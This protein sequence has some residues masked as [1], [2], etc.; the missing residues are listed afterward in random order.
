MPDAPRWRA[1]QRHTFVYVARDAHAQV[2]DTVGDPAFRKL[3]AAWLADERPLIVR[4]QTRAFVPDTTPLAVGLALPPAEGKLRLALHV[5]PAAIDRLAPPPALSEVCAKLSLRWQRALVELSRRA[6]DQGIAFRVFGSA[7]WQT[8]TGLQYLTDHS[9]IDLLW[10]PARRESLEA[11]IAILQAC[12]DALGPPLDGEILFGIDAA[13]SWR[14]WTQC[15]GSERV[16]VKSLR[17]ASLCK[18]EKLLGLLQSDATA[19]T[20]PVL[21]A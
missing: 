6:A 21:A 2:A 18:R 4:R 14:E 8:V 11:G 15:A 1:L 3:V 5:A 16:L 17:G 19:M 9:D 7:A 12:S 20:A 10:Q 13:V